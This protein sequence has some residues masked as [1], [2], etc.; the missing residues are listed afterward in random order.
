MYEVLNTPFFGI[1]MTT[2]AY[3]TAEN[4]N[5]LFAIRC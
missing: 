2:V 3:A 1:V 4:L 5:S